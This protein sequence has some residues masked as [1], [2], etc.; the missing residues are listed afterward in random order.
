VTGRRFLG[1]TE[2]TP[3]AHAVPT[4][5]EAQLGS[6]NHGIAHCTKKSIEV[7]LPCSKL[8]QLCEQGHVSP[9]PQP[10][11]HFK[12]FETPKK[13]ALVERD[14]TGKSKGKKRKPFINGFRPA[15][16]SSGKLGLR[17]LAVSAFRGSWGV[18]PKQKKHCFGVMVSWWAEGPSESPRTNFRASPEIFPCQVCKNK[19]LT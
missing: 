15:N 1:C 7:V 17:L 6:N 10:Q 2:C 11:T 18:K 12:Q 9:V 5:T 14:R 16:Y 13:A 4:S 19:Y 3:D 8:E